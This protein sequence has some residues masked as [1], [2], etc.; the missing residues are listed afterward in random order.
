MRAVRISENYATL[1][2]SRARFDSAMALQ[3]SCRSGG[4]GRRVRLKSGWPNGRASS[5]LAFGTKILST[6][7]QVV[8]YLSA[9]QASRVRF[10]PC[11]PSFEEIVWRRLVHQV[12][13]LE[14]RIRLCRRHR[15]CQRCQQYRLRRIQRPLRFR[16]F[17]MALSSW[18][19]QL[20][21][22]IQGR[23]SL[24]VQTFATQYGVTATMRVEE[25]QDTGQHRAV[26]VAG[27]AS[28]RVSVG[29]DG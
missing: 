14:Q 23:K 27:R 29:S 12:C 1:R 20:T 7:R 15:I 3:V 5:S 17:R 6:G 8:S 16:V 22:R 25:V 24:V 4:I 26:E 28:V 9:K 13:S 19:S 21:R 11:A 2:T 10:S 18:R